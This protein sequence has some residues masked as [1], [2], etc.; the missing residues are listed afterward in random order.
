MWQQCVTLHAVHTHEM[1]VLCCEQNQGL[2]LLICGL[3][4]DLDCSR[5]QF[6]RFWAENVSGAECDVEVT[7]LLHVFCG[8]VKLFIFLL[9][10]W[11]AVPRHVQHFLKFGH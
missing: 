7:Q 6:T 9:S 4:S 11:Q 8:F 5:L 2:L 10:Q 1:V 3:P